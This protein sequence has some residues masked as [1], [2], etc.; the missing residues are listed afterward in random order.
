M[1]KVYT[2]I[3]NNKPYLVKWCGYMKFDKAQ[4]METDGWRIP[5]TNELDNIRD[6]YCVKVGDFA[7]DGKI[8]YLPTSK[9]GYGYNGLST[10]FST[11]N[12]FKVG[13]SS[14]TFTSADFIY[15]NGVA[16]IKEY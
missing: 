6:S 5:T 11:D 10:I 4:E 14:S 16:L 3:I 2:I 13:A 12:V 8:I 9:D 7:V 15:T 1:N